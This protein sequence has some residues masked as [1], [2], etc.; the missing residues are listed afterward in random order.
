MRRGIDAITAHHGSVIL[1]LG[2]RRSESPERAKRMQ[3]RDRTDAG[4]NP[5]GEIP[6]ALV[7]TPLM[8]WSTDAVWEHLLGHAPPWGGDHRALYDLY[9]QAEG[10]ECPV[11]LDLSQPSCG[12]SRFGCW[13]CTVVKLDK[14][15]QGFIDSGEE[16]MRPLNAFRDR[17]KAVR[18][19]PE[20]RM[21]K[22]RSG[23]ITIGRKGPFTPEKRKILLEELLKLEMICKRSLISDAE[24]GYIQSVWSQEFDVSGCAAL[25]LAHQSGRIPVR[26]EGAMAADIH[27]EVLEEVL[28]D[29]PLDLELVQRLLRLAYEYH[30]NLDHYGKKTEFQRAIRETIERTMD[31][32]EEN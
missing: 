18:E 7:A 4:L 24:L 16:W 26:W 20:W 30:P 11:I 22:R 6:N 14:S 27:H 13:T 21:D 25:Q 15:M 10:G 12:G 17:L 3:G 32:P 1:L 28:V 9:R 29:S 23:A 5:H 31:N 19:L 2:T 8:D